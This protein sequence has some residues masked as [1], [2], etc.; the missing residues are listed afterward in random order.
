MTIYALSSG[1]GIS[2]VAVIRMSGPESKLAIEK[3]KCKD[4]SNLF[5]GPT[6]VAFGEDA[7][8]SARILSKFAKENENFSEPFAILYADTKDQL[9][10]RVLIIQEALVYSLRNYRHFITNVVINKIEKKIFFVTSNY[11]VYSTEQANGQ[12]NLFSTGK[13]IAEIIFKEKY[14]Y[15]KKLDVLIDTFSIPRQMPIPL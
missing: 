14:P 10:D 4:L 6:A 12:T 1:P 5:T 13:Y 9:K 11:V 8:M 3:T 15:F 2:G 7:I